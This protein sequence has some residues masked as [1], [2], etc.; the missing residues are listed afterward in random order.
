MRGNGIG[1]GMVPS[2]L[3]HVNG[4][5]PHTHNLGLHTTASCSQDTLVLNIWGPIY[6][7]L[8][9]HTPPLEETHENVLAYSM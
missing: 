3:F 4:S 6:L 5:Q 1:G 9:P 2:L 7:V 8:L